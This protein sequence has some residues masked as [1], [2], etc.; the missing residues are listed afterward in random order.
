MPI[1][2]E[3]WE[4]HRAERLNDPAQFKEATGGYGVAPCWTAPTV[5]RGKV[6]IRY[7]DRLVCYDLMEAGSRELAATQNPDTGEAGN[8]PAKPHIVTDRPPASANRY[9][10]GQAPKAA[11]TAGAGT[12]K[13]PATRTAS[14]VV[15]QRPGWTENWPQ[16]RGPWGDGRAAADVDPPAT[17]D[18]AKD[19]RFSTAL[20]ARGRSSP[21]VW[22]NRIYL[23]GEDACVMAFDR[24]TGKLQWNTTL[25]VPGAVSEPD[26]DEPGPAR[27][28]RS[29]GGAAP[30]PLTDGQ[31]VYAFFGNGLLG[32]VDSGGKQIWAR[33]LVSGGPGICTVWPPVRSS[34]ATC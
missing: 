28:G 23:T 9:L 19:T 12:G 34:T 22:G 2:L 29:A 5:A 6:Y 32:C 16:F 7:S 11:S 24:E 15:P 18:L 31:F 17:L 30:T 3:A 10:P 26:H 1:A 13:T 8:S 27:V 20:P 4:N 14:T 21:I 25:K 33:V